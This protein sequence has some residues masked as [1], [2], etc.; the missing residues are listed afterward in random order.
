LKGG[1]WGPVRDRCRPM[2]IAHDE[3]FAF[4]QIGFRCCS[5][6]SAPTTQPAGSARHEMIAG[7]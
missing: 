7:S 2:T 5:E 6:A 4:Y 3:N 1:Y